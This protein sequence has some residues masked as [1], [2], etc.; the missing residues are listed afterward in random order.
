[1]TALSQYLIDQNIAI[2]GITILQQAIWTLSRGQR[3]V[4]TNLH[5]RLFCL[6]LAAKR[7]DSARLFLDLNAANCFLVGVS[8]KLY[9]VFQSL[10]IDFNVLERQQSVQ[11]FM[12]KCAA[13]FLLRWFDQVGVE[14]L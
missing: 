9:T 4:L 5:A 6:C 11:S 2:H 14:G 13:L 1:M 12:R 7:F 10:H 8:R 3:G